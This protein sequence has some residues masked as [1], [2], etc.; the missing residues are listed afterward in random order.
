M[1]EKFNSRLI[2]SLDKESN[3]NEYEEI[4][5]IYNH[6]QNNE[7]KKLIVGI[8]FSGDVDTTNNRENKYEDIIPIFEKFRQKGL[9]I[10]INLGEK[11]N[12]QFVPLNLF[13][14]DRDSNGCF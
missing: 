10:S 5:E 13:V 11:Q 4:L 9:G 1:S 14:P 6:I 2:I 7:L 8:D 3:I 12:Y